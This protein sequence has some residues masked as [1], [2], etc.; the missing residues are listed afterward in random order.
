MSYPVLILRR[1]QKELA[2]LSTESYDQIRD[3]IR[4]LANNS[5]PPGCLKLTA[6]EAWRIRV[7]DYR[8]VYEIDDGQKR[9]QSFTW[10][11]VAMCTGRGGPFVR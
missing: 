7:G 9:L 10:G 8:V 3:A 6:R 2:Q 11:I 5:R 1:A 4:E